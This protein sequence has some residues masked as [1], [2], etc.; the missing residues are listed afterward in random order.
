M[1]DL[2][3][4]PDPRA[5][6]AADKPE[7]RKRSQID[8]VGATPYLGVHLMCL[9]VFWVGFSW[10]A[11]SVALLLY[12]LRMFAITAFYHR[13]FSH[14]AFKTSR[15][16][17]FLFAALGCTALQQ[18][19]LWWAAHHRHHHSH[20][21]DS[22]DMHSPQQLGFW[23]SHLGWFLA[24]DAGPTN[25]KLVPD[26]A[27]F[28]ELRW[29]DRYHYV[30]AIVL[31]AILMSSGTLLSVYCPSWQADGWQL[32]IWGFVSTIAVY[33]ATY[34]VNSLAHVVGRRRYETKD[35]SRNNFWI[36]LLT[37]GEGWHN[38]HHHYPNSA[39]QGFFWWELDFTYYILKGMSWVGLVWDLRPVAPHM[40]NRNLTSTQ[41]SQQTQGSMADVS[42]QVKV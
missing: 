3:T 40:L 20:S 10:T 12:A 34:K 30:P 1:N 39:R 6:R 29:L 35:N 38:N 19:P 36:A 8:W 18:G 28:P 22:E 41:D 27:K 11:L 37:F 5:S 4:P 16:C 13:Y 32:L 23:W 24:P 17:Q 25:W 2:D 21:D 15:V 7:P 26:F 14:R 33:H 31:A 9:G 42:H